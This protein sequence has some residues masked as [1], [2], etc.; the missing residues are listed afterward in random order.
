[1]NMYINSIQISYYT[2]LY[3]WGLIIAVV[4][5]W[6]I[7]LGLIFSNKYTKTSTVI[8]IVLFLFAFVCAITAIILP[9]DIYAEYGETRVK[10]TNEERILIENFQKYGNRESSLNASELRYLI[11][12]LKVKK[13]EIDYNKFQEP[14]K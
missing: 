1:M 11:D 14:S 5:F 8:G 13:E 10:I 2:P 9:P 6:V 3:V 4:V 7:A 12:Q